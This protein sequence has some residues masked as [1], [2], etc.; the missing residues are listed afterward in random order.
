MQYIL[1][2]YVQEDRWTKLTKAEQEQG[3]ARLRGVHRGTDEGRR[4]HGREPPPGDL[5]RNHCAPCEWQAPGAG[6]TLCGLEGAAGRL[7][8]H[9]RGRSRCRHLVGGPM[10]GCRSRRR[11]GASALGHDG[12]SCV[13]A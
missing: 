9:R 13:Q 12:V 11:R 5:D 3:V 4:P 6:W 1:M 8:H 2:A 10:P 7:L